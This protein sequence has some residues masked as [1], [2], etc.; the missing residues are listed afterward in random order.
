MNYSIQLTQ[1]NLDVIICRITISAYHTM[2]SLSGNGRL[3]T[4]DEGIEE[5]H[6]SQYC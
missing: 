2:I 5:V 1:T 6:K 3:K 4:G